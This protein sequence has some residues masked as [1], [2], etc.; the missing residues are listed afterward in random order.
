MINDS[1]ALAMAD[2]D[3]GARASVHVPSLI[4]SIM[5]TEHDHTT[6]SKI[7]LDHTLKS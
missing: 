1:R 6:D 4:L 2:Y 3:H 7:K 5:I